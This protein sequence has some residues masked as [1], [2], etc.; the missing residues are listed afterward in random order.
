MTPRVDNTAP[1]ARVIEPEDRVILAPNER[2]AVVGKSRSGKTTFTSVLAHTIV[3]DDLIEHDWQVWWIDTKGDPR[4]I[5]RLQKLGFQQ[6][7]PATGEPSRR[8]AFY[9]RRQKVGRLYF[10]VRDLGEDA[11]IVNQVQHICRLAMR[12]RRVLLVLDEYTQVVV[13]P[14]TCGRPL[15]DLFTRGGG[16]GVG[17][18]GGTQ[19]PVNI[20]RKLLSQATHLLVFDLSFPSDQEYMRQFITG[21]DRPPRHEAHAFW[22]VWLDGDAIPRYYPSLGAWRSRVVEGA[23]EWPQ[24][25]SSRESA[26]SS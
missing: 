5:A 14:R 7:D 22:H 24:G 17:V 21:Y 8:P 25:T 19:E 18:I 3:S 26:T 16:L 12:R 6:G 9:E 23:T 20:P 15:D 2:F 1:V 10:R 4:D 13:G 11:T